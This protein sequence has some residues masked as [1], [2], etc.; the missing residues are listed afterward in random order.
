MS[1][2]II[3][4]H[5]APRI[6][7]MELFSWIFA[8]KLIDSFFALYCALPL[9]AA[10]TPPNRSRLIAKSIKVKV[11]SRQTCHILFCLHWFA[12]FFVISFLSQIFQ[13][14]HAAGVAELPNT[15][16]C[17]RSNPMELRPAPQWAHH[18]VLSYTSIYRSYLSHIILHFMP[19]QPKNPKSATHSLP[20][21]LTPVLTEV[22][23]EL[24]H[25]P[26]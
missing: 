20:P 16:L 12:W 1:E 14:L 11:K 19:P 4:Q 21:V 7:T 23:R 8:A 3:T 24:W 2:G 9:F 17:G 18:V 13:H 10:T 22:L 26:G 25:L 5:G 6:L 15:W